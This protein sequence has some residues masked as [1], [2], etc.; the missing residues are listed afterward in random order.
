M[1][2]NITEAV[3]SSGK[4]VI[5]GDSGGPVYTVLQSGKQP[6][7]VYAK[8]IISGGRCSS[9]FSSN[10]SDHDCSDATD[11]DC[12][13]DFTDIALAEKALPGGVKKW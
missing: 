6:G 7:Y 5:G 10:N 1:A 4:C 9:L 13:V 11:L 12:V 3:K 2:H 8:G